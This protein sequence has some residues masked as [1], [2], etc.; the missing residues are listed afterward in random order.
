MRP[1]RPG[2]RA[3]RVCAPALELIPP[4]FNPAE[5]WHMTE[6]MGDRWWVIGGG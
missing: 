2:H 6:I 4:G 5:P 1:C 3:R